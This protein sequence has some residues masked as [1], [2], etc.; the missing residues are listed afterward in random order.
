V[1]IR[2]TTVYWV[3]LKLGD[4]HVQSHLSSILNMITFAELNVYLAMLSRLFATICSHGNKIE[5]YM[6]RT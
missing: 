6:R 4:G 1:A 5:K 3:N 2:Q